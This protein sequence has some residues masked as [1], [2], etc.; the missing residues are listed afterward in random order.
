MYLNRI[1]SFFRNQKSTIF[2]SLYFRNLVLILGLRPIFWTRDLGLQ[3]VILRDPSPYLRK[4]RRKPRKT[5]NLWVDKSDRGL[6]L[7]PFVY[8][9]E[10]T[11]LGHWWGY[12]FLKQETMKK[13]NVLDI[14]KCDEKQSRDLENSR[15]KKCF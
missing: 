12:F 14:L 9:F 5:P 7:V 1:V 13:S 3:G 8:S 15:F 6:N 10:K 4:F 2:R 11:T